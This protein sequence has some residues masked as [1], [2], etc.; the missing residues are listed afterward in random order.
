MN[1]PFSLSFLRRGR[2]NIFVAFFITAMLGCSDPAA[3]PGDGGFVSMHDATSVPDG[4]EPMNDATIS[5]DSGE[6]CTDLDRD[7]YGDG[8]SDGADCNDGDGSVSPAATEVCNGVD[9]DCDT[10]VDEGVTAPTCELVLG[11]C[12]GATR[13]CDATGFLACDGTDYG[14]TYQA[15]ETLC[16]GLDNDCDGTTDEGC[17]CIEG[18]TQACGSDVGECTRGTQTCT[19]AVF[20]ACEGEVAPQGEVCDGLD[21][22]CDGASD[23]PADL[24]AP[25]CPLQ[26]G[27][28]AGSHRTCG[29]AA[30]FIACSGIASYGGDYQLEESLCDGLDNDCDGVTDEGCECVEGHTQS[31]GTDIGECSRGTQTCIAGGWGTCAGSVAPSVEACDGLDNDC[32]GAVDIGMIAPPCALQQGVCAGRSQRCSGAVG[33][34][35]CSTADYGASYQVMES[36]CDGLDNDC[37]GIVDEGCEC[38]TGATQACGSAVGAC[39]R[40]TQTCHAGEWSEC[41]GGTAPSTEICNGIDDNC[42]GVVDEGLSAPSCS[43]TA[44]VCAG[45]MQACGSSG[46]E[47]CSGAA[48]YGPRYMAV[49]DG[50]TN[51]AACDGLDNDCDGVMDEHCTSGPLVSDPNDTVWPALYHRGLAYSANIDGNWDIVFQHLDRGPARRITTTPAHEAGVQISGDHLAYVR[52]DGAARR[53]VLYHLVTG[54]ETVLNNRETD[55]VDVAAGFVVWD[56]LDAGSWNVVVRRIAT[57]ERTVI[58]SPT[59]HEFAPSIRGGVLSY[60]GASGGRALVHVVAYDEEANAFGSP[61]VQMPAGSAGA[62]QATVHHDFTGIV[63]TDGRAIA[64]TP[65]QTSDWDIYGASWGE[66]VGFTAYP[67]EMALA[68]GAAAEVVTGMDSQLIVFNDFQNGNW[69]VG[70]VPLGGEPFLVTSSDALQGEAALSGA[71]LVWQDNRL[72]S[73]DI[74]QA[75][76]VGALTTPVPGALQIGEV[77]AEPAPGADVNG[78]GI[79]NTAH[80]EFVEIIN[81]SGVPVNLSGMTLSD[82]A[83]GGTVRHVFPDGTIL[84]ALG[85][86]VVFGGG[87][88]SGNFGSAAVQVASSGMLSLNNEGEALTLRASDGTVIDEASYG[89]IGGNEVAIVRDG[90]GWIRHTFVPNSIGPWSPGLYSD[91]FVP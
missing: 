9:D 89:S 12:A 40:G 15:T 17:S 39:M 44:G 1:H 84:P 23:E 49:E 91:G 48:S 65:S 87:T 11:V 27:V 36:L 7:G 83:N 73:Y 31:C 8:C 5:D 21:N 82:A 24:V 76:V 90:T 6:S 18:A 54:V 63:W 59:T 72:G 55:R 43:L 68:T 20:S 51:E 47:V 45:A 33:F 28:C 26:L 2:T 75:F 70:V 13:R 77:L 62:G 22:D 19:G 74:Y 50:R 37:D 35:E 10:H 81:A 86:I 38:I 80:E 4:S 14:A 29:G 78:D 88:P 32:D 57:G 41:S 71:H 16:D 85:I 60:I 64:G 53:A 46:W 42:N 66:A 34:V 3:S 67:G 61:V 52:G 79:V 58:G 69:D 25:A 30:G 56:E